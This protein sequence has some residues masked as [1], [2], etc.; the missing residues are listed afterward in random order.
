MADRGALFVDNS[1]EDKEVLVAFLG[2]QGTMV[3][4]II[5]N[6]NTAY[7]KKHSRNE[8]PHKRCI[9]D[10]CTLATELT[11]TGYGGGRSKSREGELFHEEVSQ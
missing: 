7:I 10:W 1:T 9:S 4:K 5:T 2:S 6:Q 8:Q 11:L 3:I